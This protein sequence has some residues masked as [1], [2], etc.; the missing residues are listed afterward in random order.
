VDEAIAYFMDLRVRAWG[1]PEATA[2]VDR[3]LALLARAAEADATGLLNIEAEIESL[4]SEL[5]RRF[6]VARP[7]VFH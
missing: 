2:L 3:C 7:L 6:G 4:R 1:R 5:E